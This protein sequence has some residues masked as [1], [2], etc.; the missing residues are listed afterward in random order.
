MKYHSYSLPHRYAASPL[1]R[2]ATCLSFA[3]ALPRMP[4]SDAVCLASVILVATLVI[5]ISSVVERHPESIATAG[6][7][8]HVLHT[9]GLAGRWLSSAKRELVFPK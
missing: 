4:A 1:I 7:L 9:H 5:F 2:H 3:V 8:R 6:D